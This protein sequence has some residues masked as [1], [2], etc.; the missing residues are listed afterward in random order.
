MQNYN[1]KAMPA[2]SAY[3]GEPFNHLQHI[4]YVGWQKQLCIKGLHCQ[5]K[6]DVA[7]NGAGKYCFVK[8]VLIWCLS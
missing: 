1:E 8:Y 7:W 2:S 6:I 3:L 4:S 5:E